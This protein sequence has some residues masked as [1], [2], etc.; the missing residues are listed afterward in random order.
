MI[1]IFITLFVLLLLFSLTK[2]YIKLIYIVIGAFICI[3]SSPK[4]LYEFQKETFLGMSSYLGPLPI[5]FWIIIIF[6]VTFCFRLIS[7]KKLKL[8]PLVLPMVLFFIGSS[9]LMSLI[10]QIIDTSIFSLSSL[11]YLITMLA[12]CLSFLYNLNINLNKQDIFKVM[13]LLIN[14]SIGKILTS[15]LI[16]LLGR[17]G[18]HGDLMNFSG[19]IRTISPMFPILVILYSLIIYLIIN[20]KYIASSIIFI[21]FLFQNIIYFQRGTIVMLLWGALVCVFLSVKFTSFRKKIVKVFLIMS[22]MTITLLTMIFINLNDFHKT[23][24]NR[25][26]PEIISTSRESL[27]SIQFKNI[28]FELNE[29]PATLLF[30]GG[31]CNLMN[32]DYYESKNEITTSAHTQIE[33]DNNQFIPHSFFNIIFMK[34]GLVGLLIYLLFFVRFFFIIVNRYKHLRVEQESIEFLI[35]L[36]SLICLMSLC[37]VMPVSIGASISF[38][39]LYGLTFHLKRSL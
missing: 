23:T 37:W 12:F 34:L 36:T 28:F 14:G 17:A 6:F 33:H 13:S 2:N 10:F 32:Y 7:I 1:G 20:K 21:F 5:T 16:L 25:I 3:D 30:G 11:R 22:V 24:L 15:P 18:F 9:C 39:I 19:I 29:H 35:F 26:V 27:R 38:G 8:P 31:V 4:H